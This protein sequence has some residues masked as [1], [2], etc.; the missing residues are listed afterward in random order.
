[1]IKYIEID[2]ENKIN[3]VDLRRIYNIL[4]KLDKKYIFYIRFIRY[5][6]L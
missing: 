3:N 4:Y 5:I 1:M 2:V 6:L